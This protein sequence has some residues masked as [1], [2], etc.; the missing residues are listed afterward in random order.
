MEIML[1]IAVIAAVLFF[2]AL[3]SAGNERQRRAIDALREQ[4]E[5]WAI[6][7]L[8][9]KRERLAREI[10]MDDPLGWLNRLAAKVCSRDMNLHVTQAFE[11][12]RALLSTGER[13]TDR[14]VFSPLS[15]GDIRRLR[16][17]GR[18]RLSNYAIENPLLHLPP[19]IAAHELSI[20]SCGMFFDLEFPLA[21]KALTDQRVE[22]MDRLWM[23]AAE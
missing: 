17:K 2:G 8:R 3:I 19:N 14:V 10:R 13:D 9:L 4:P 23:C 15:P 1:A 5:L 20:L 11:E 18:N 6:Q 7:D 12:P 21:W 22:Q 16:R